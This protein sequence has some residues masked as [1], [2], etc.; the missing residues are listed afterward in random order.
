MD[1]ENNNTKYSLLYKHN[2]FIVW[3]PEYN[4][5]IPI[6]DEHHRGIVS[7]IN[8]LH[9]S[10]QNKQVRDIFTSISDMIFDY[11]KIHFRTEE[12]FHSMVDFSGAKDHHELHEHLISELSKLGRHGN[13]NKNPDEFLSFLKNWWIGHICF[14]DLKFRDYLIVRDLIQ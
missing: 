5:G 4:L 9:F 6:I 12:S 1:H 13:V 10:M 2:V 14:E 3:K 8:S 7:T 11:T